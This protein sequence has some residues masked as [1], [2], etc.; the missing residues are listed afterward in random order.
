M[1]GKVPCDPTPRIVQYWT[2]KT[3]YSS[4]V[5]SVSEEE[6]AEKYLMT[7]THL[8]PCC[9]R[10][11]WLRRRRKTR[12]KMPPHRRIFYI[13]KTVLQSQ[14][15]M[16]QR[17]LVFT[18]CCCGQRHLASQLIAAPSCFLLITSWPAVFSSL[19]PRTFQHFVAP[20]H[21]IPGSNHAQTF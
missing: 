11:A 17:H 4:A 10:A 19:S 20:L 14:R 6:C 9:G 5:L 8:P 12:S 21:A 16:H 18:V 15:A 1:H 7:P 2:Q 13:T 3:V